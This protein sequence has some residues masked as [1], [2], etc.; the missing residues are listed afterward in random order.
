MPAPV[1]RGDWPDDFPALDDVVPRR[2]GKP[3]RQGGESR[4]RHQHGKGCEI[5]QSITRYRCGAVKADGG[6][7]GLDEFAADLALC[8]DRDEVEATILR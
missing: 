4:A 5:G 2:A 3:T 8:T 1:I 7:V 6:G